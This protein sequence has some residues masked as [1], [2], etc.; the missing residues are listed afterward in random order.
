MDKDNILKKIKKCFAL[1]KSDNPNEAALA[2]KMAQELINKYQIRNEDIRMAD[3]SG[4]KTR[5][6]EAQNPAQYLYALVNMIKQ[7]FGC[8][9]VLEY[10]F[11]FKIGWFTIVSFI[12]F[13]PDPELACYAYSVLQKQL[14]KGRKQYVS[15]L[16]KD[17]KRTT[18]IRRG[19]LWAQSWINSVAKKAV[20]LT[21]GKDK[22]SLLKQWK[23]KHY[24]NLKSTSGRIA[25]KNGIGD[26]S[27]II[28][29]YVAGKKATLHHGVNG[30]NQ[31][32]NML[33]A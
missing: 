11:S 3:I 20:Y 17:L 2:L 32:V 22:E 26:T 8:E 12:G 15:K 19:D 30:T 7:V 27:A 16:R 28:E 5:M 1:G 14:V 21:V 33:T 13:G 9:A 25:K 23:D 24:Q 6:S 10:D 31:A 29:G 18:K 4:I